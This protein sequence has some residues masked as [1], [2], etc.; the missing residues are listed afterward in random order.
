MN[1]NS[2]ITG[3][4]KAANV[5][6]LP[7]EEILELVKKAYADNLSDEDVARIRIALRGAGVSPGYHDPTGLAASQYNQAILNARNASLGENSQQQGVRAGLTSAIPG[8]LIGGAGGHLAGSILNRPSKSRI[9]N[10]IG[11]RLPK[12][13][14]IAG[15][16]GGGL[17]SGIPAYEARENTI[18]DLQKLNDP[19][20]VERLA[21]TIQ[22]DKVLLNS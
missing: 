19:N 18:R 12:G 7:E 11:S 16:I 3:F 2:F 1:T 8:V 9:L 17:I 13:L 14:G 15:A 20:N 4:V 10:A 5:S 21:R 6:G 22:A